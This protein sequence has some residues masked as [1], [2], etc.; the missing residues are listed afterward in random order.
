MLNDGRHLLAIV[1]RVQPS[2]SKTM[3]LSHTAEQEKINK[4]YN[5][6]FNK[7]DRKVTANMKKIFFEKGRGS[8]VFLSEKFCNKSEK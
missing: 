4:K 6:N 3:H 7:A 8:K 1:Q 5:V 2:D